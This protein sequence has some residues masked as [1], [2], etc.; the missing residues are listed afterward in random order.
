M[1]GEIA[2]NE[3]FENGRLN[4]PAAER[5]LYPRP[6]GRPEHDWVGRRMISN[7]TLRFVRSRAGSFAVMF[8]LMLPVFATFIVFI[9]DQANMAHLQSRVREA[10]D[11]ATVAAAQEFLTGK[12]THAQLE[13]YAKDFLLANLGE[14]YREALKVELTVPKTVSSGSFILEAHLKYVPMLSPVYAAAS[15][16]PG[17]EFAINIH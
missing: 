1:F 7:A 17:S 11:A 6:I 16:N 5:N 2:V 13:A 15:G 4:W 8:A 12:R 10:R 9:S 3:G 14:E